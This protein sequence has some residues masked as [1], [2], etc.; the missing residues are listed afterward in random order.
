MDLEGA[1]AQEGGCAAAAAAA[2]ADAA[3]DGKSSDDAAAKSASGLTHTDRTTQS[4]CSMPGQL[5]TS[6]HAA[7]IATSSATLAVRVSLSE[8]Y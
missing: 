3:A 5:S 1:A 2:A 7:V 4:D 6:E 8:W